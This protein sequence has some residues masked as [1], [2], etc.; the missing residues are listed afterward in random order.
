MMQRLALS[1]R[2]RL[3]S[4]D[5]GSRKAAIQ[6]NCRPTLDFGGTWQGLP[7]KRWAHHAHPS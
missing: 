3:A 4:T 2:L 7:T 5:A 1:A 6:S